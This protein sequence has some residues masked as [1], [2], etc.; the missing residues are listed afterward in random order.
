M[1]KKKI[2][3][4]KMFIYLSS[5]RRLQRIFFYNHAYLFFCLFKNISE[6]II[7]RLELDSV[8][9]LDTHFVMLTEMI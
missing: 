3:I 7:N 2:C 5:A 1:N 9:L 6:K 4:K 8:V